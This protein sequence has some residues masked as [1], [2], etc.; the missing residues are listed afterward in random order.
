LEVELVD[1][2][3]VTVTVTVELADEAESALEEFV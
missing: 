2:G 3:L 1:D